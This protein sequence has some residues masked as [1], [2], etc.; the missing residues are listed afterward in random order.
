MSWLQGLDESLFRFINHTLSNPLFD[1]LMPWLSGNRM[2]IPIGILAGAVFI[3]RGKGRAALFLLLLAIAVGVTDG[4]VCNTLKH[5]IGR[6]RPCAALENVHLLVGCGANGAMPSSHAGNMFAAATVAFLFYRRSAWVMFPLAAAVGFS[7]IANGVHYPSDVVVGAILGMGSGFAVIFTLNALW[8]FVGAKWFP[9]WHA[10][11][12]SLVPGSGVSQ[13]STL[14]PQPNE[15]THWFRAGCILIVFITL[16]RWLYL[17]SGTIELSEDEAYQWVWSKHLAWSYYSK[18]PLIALTQ[19][20]STSI[21]GDTAFGVRFFSP[22]I[23]ATLG[24]L[25]LRFFTREVNGRAGFFLVL[26]VAATPLLSVGATL[27]TVDPLTV[28]F[29]TATMLAGWKAVQEN[30]RTSDWLWTGLWMGLGFLS[31]YSS[32]LMWMCWAVFFIVWPPARKHLRTRGPWLALLV[33]L[34]CTLPVLIWNMQNG[35]I[36]LKHVA[37]HTGVGKAAAPLSKHLSWLVEFLGAEIALLNPIFFFAA[38]I[39]LIA[40]WRTAKR[41]ARMV[42]LFCMGAPVFILYIFLSLRS[43]VQP[44]WVAPSVLPMFAVMVIYWDARMRAGATRVK[45]WLMAG[46]LTGLVFVT[47][48][49]ESR[50]VERLTGR[51]LPAKIDPLTRVRAHSELARVVGEAQQT[52][53]KEGR[54]VFV[55]GDHYGITSLLMFYMPDAK[56][57]VAN[58]P[59]VYCE[60]SDKPVDQYYFWPGYQE[61]RRGQSAIFVSEREE[62]KLVEGWLS[63]WWRG[64]ADFVEPV[65]AGEPAPEWLTKQFESVRSIGNHKINRRGQT[66]HVIEMYECRNLR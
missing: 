45:W 1:V 38:A 17:A 53:A 50:L 41:D 61:A 16:A 25:L 43:R 3:W 13:P 56:S 27:L 5:A 24:F 28:L 60:P 46:L 8:R 33:N 55:I 23:A 51:A 63:K 39:A 52:L 36:S 35:W 6:A 4:L 48:M 44:N 59:F 57:R 11:L 40:I 15:D 22:L 29:W 9:L 42:F 18:P 20:V 62:A 31:K 34:L 7:R 66:Y 54:P 49:K 47:V 14:N 30:S 37:R 2:F 19:F 65:I 58:D 64:E 12:P 21:W 10:Q 32:P 26:I